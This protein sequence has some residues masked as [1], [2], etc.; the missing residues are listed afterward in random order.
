M[1]MNNQMQNQQLTGTSQMPA[2]VSHG[3]HELFDAHG[4]HRWFSW[5]YGAIYDL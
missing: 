2:E 3:G 5:W 1:N 4:A